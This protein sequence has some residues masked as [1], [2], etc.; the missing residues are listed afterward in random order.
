MGEGMIP[1]DFVERYKDITDVE[2]L[3]AC[4]EQ[5]LPKSFRINTLKAE[6]AMVLER[7]K[8]YGISLKAVPW[9]EDAFIA[10][11]HDIGLT[12]EH[13]VG[14]IY[15]QELVSMLPPVLVADCLQ[16]WSKVL[17][18]CA[19][20]GSKTTQLAALMR[21]KGL[22]VANDIDYVRIKA[23]KSNIERCGVFNTAIT[24]YDLRRFPNMRFDVVLLDAPCSAEGTA[25][26]NEE[27]FYLWS[28]KKILNASRLQKQLILRAFD[29][30]KPGGVLLYSTCTLAPEENEEV[31]DF[32]LSKRNAYLEEVEIKGWRYDR[33][34]EEWQGKRFSE[35]V[36]KAVRIWPHQND[37]GGFF[38]ARIR[39]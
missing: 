4:L 34:L 23:L 26:K 7:F 32:L 11:K 16:E 8:E 30:L 28:V 33:A 18:G 15:V 14:A 12:L 2:L 24:N 25:R 37:S 3:C 19:A 38:I 22:I 21:N 9:Y 20:P 31:V 29:L 36:S 27:V 13:F 6:R 5:P 1:A 17:D 10:D 35:E 39:K